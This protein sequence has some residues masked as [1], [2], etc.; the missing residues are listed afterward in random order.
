MNS[1]FGYTHVSPL[2]LCVSPSAVSTA[3]ASSLPHGIQDLSVELGDDSVV[4]CVNAGPQ[5]SVSLLVQ[6]AQVLVSVSVDM[7]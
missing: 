2:L 6:A 3:A 4:V 5:E 1:C 7:E